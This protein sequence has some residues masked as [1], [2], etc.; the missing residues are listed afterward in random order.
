LLALRGTK[1]LGKDVCVR[2]YALIAG[3]A[4]A[5]MAGSQEGT[6]G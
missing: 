2:G 3:Q 5:L 6:A 4:A 1:L